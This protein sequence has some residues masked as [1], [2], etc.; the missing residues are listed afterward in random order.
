MVWIALAIAL[1]MTFMSDWI[2]EML[3]GVAYNE[4]GMVLMI[5]IWAGVFV[6]LGVASSKWFV[7]ENLQLLSMWRTFFGMLVNVLLNILLIPKYGITGA[8][9]ST[10][11]SQVVAAYLFDV[12]YYKTRSMFYM[13]T[14]SLLLLRIN[15]DR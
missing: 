2:V 6:F 12:F 10:L 7:A 11:I 9:F 4:A 13:K 1:P 3:Y 15:N 5:H 8:A 14:K